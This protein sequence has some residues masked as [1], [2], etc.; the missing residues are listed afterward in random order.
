MKSL[1]ETRKV[2]VEL[3]DL[4]SEVMELKKEN[5]KIRAELGDIKKRIDA[6]DPNSTDGS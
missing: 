4:R 3:R 2:P 6:K 5:E 1:Y